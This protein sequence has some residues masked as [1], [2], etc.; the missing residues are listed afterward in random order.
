MKTRL[1]HNMLVPYIGIGFT[2]LALFLQP[3]NEF[4]AGY[5]RIL[6]STS[7]L[8]TDYVSVGGIGP[9]L[10]NSGSLILLSYIII[11]KLNLRITGSIFAGIMTIGGFAFFGKNIIN[12]SI[13]YFGVL[14]YSKYRELP[15]K[16]V[17]IVF[18]FSTGLS[19]ISS[20]VMFG[21]GLP[22]LF[23]IPLGILLGVLSGFMIVELSSHVISFH[24][25]YN[26][27]NVGFAGGILAFCYFSIFKLMNIDYTTNLIFT[28]D[29]HLLLLFL[30][31][32]IC[33]C[34]IV[35]GFFLNNK[36]ITEYFNITKLSGRAVTDFT[37]KDN[38]ALTMV[39]I[40]LTGLAALLILLLLNVHMNGPVMGGLLTIVGFS[41]FGKHPRNVIPPMI[42]V[43]LI[44]LLFGIELSVPVV[45][46]VIFS[47]ALAPIAGE[48]GWIIGIFS[49]MLHLPITLS[50][51]QLHGGVLLYSNGF[52]AAFTAVI[53]IT[54]IHTFR[55]SD[56]NGFTRI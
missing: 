1:R 49:G 35:V 29:Q 54:I 25:G 36:P 43:L 48:F 13:I 40:G 3:F 11:R 32:L 31:I 30:Y 6:I 20:V 2:I 27:Y 46:A 44:T 39:N 8:L 28:N 10:F 33:V 9:A 51:S 38:Q 4:L 56:K 24:H 52:A 18:L 7:I 47:T 12:V 16:N 21:V 26:L 5:S 37:R 55:K 23:S 34:Y 53:I 22:L 42:G 15:L 19:P 45:L 17:I 14:L 41:A 50:I